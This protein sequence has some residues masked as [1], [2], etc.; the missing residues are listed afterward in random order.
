[1]KKSKI[2]IP[3]VIAVLAIGVIAI[4]AIMGDNKPQQLQTG[5]KESNT[6]TQ[7]KEPKEV[8]LGKTIELGFIKM[9][10]DKVEVK[11]ECKFSYKEKTSWGSTTHSSSITC[12]SGMKLVCLRGK[13]TNLSTEGVYTSNDF[14]K[15][16]SCNKWQ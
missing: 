11:P 2:I 8:S 6:K 3:I 7:E 4:I 14:V 15:R 5:A 13:I 10:L 16:R 1:M 9:T 12:K